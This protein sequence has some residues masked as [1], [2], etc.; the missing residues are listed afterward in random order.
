MTECNS[1]IRDLLPEYLHEQLSLLDAQAAELHLTSC[2]ECANE[3]AL[4]RRALA[5]RPHAL[6]VNIASIVAQLPKPGMAGQAASITDPKVRPLSSAPSA[7]RRSRDWLGRHHRLRLAAAIT[8]VAL[9]GMSV[10]IARHGT[11]VFLPAA[12]LND[13]A[14]TV[15]AGRVAEHS[16]SVASIATTDNGVSDDTTLGALPVGELKDFSD[17]EIE[18]VIQRLD[19]WDGSTSADPLPGVPLLPPSPGG[20]Q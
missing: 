14:S 9:G 18:T 19:Q 13:S 16:A 12:S 4:L 1:E 10:A 8:V 17:D 20:T 5:V 6:S 15:A 11:S 3:L 2:A 7:V